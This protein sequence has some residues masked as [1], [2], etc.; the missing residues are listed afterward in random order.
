MTDE[1]EA[2][3]RPMLGN[4]AGHEGHLELV[5]DDRR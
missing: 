5:G 3:I 1:T 4:L 2:I